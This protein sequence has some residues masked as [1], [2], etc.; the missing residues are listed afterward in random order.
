MVSQARFL[1]RDLF[2][3]AVVLANFYGLSWVSRFGYYILPFAAGQL[4]SPA[5]VGQAISTVVGRKIM[6]S[7]T[8][9]IAGTGLI[10]VGY[11]FQH[12]LSPRPN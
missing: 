7:S 4:S 2:D 9:I 10:V 6:I 8:Y 12:T 1:Q 3:Y 11:M 5:V